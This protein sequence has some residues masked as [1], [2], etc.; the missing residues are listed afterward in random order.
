MIEERYTMYLIEVD[1]VSRQ[2]RKI[3]D[4]ALVV[5]ERILKLIRK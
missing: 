1:Q 4:C 2:I 3:V 5:G